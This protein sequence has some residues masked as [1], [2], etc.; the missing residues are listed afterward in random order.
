MEHPL[1]H[2]AKSSDV[3]HPASSPTPSLKQSGTSGPGLS[4]GRTYVR[5]FEPGSMRP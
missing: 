5:S 1:V 4:T 2:H 3:G